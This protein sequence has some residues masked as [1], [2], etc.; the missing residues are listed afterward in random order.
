M[1]NV[2]SQMVS[3]N[4]GVS[5]E[6]VS[7]FGL[8][9]NNADSGYR[10]QVDQQIVD[11]NLSS[12]GRAVIISGTSFVPIADLKRCRFNAVTRARRAA[13]HVGFLS[14]VNLKAGIY[15]SLVPVS[16]NPMGFLA[17]V[18]KIGSDL[19]L[20]NRP[21]FYRVGVKQSMLLSEASSDMRPTLSLDAR[22][23]SLDLHSCGS[24]KGE[25]VLVTEIHSGKQI[26]LNRMMC[27]KIFHFQ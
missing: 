9:M 4:R 8:F 1:S 2:F 17:V 24:G 15:T 5:V 7:D 26:K 18:G 16:V 27:E 3:D 19:N 23:V 21:G 20:V 13:P 6:K 10:C 12:D 25:G 11:V 22:Y 14:D